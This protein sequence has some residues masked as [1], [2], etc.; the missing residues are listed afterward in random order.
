MVEKWT[1]AD[2]QLKQHDALYAAMQDPYSYD[3]LSDTV[4]GMIAN[5]T[6]ISAALEPFV[7]ADQEND[8][9]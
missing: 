7:L 9:G 5:A 3:S 8:N 1:F 6:A 2:E 4:D